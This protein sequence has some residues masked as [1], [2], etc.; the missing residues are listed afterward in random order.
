[1]SCEE[2]YRVTVTMT[3]CCM[4]V[5]LTVVTRHCDKSYRGDRHSV[6]QGCVACCLYILK[7]KISSWICLL[8][9]VHTVPFMIY[10][11]LDRPN[12]LQ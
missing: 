4:G 1:M 12:K 7:A 6:H 10:K 5:C 3:A 11:E 9:E 2:L 8:S